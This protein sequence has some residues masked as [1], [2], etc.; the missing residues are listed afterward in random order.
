MA[1]TPEQ[2]AQLR[3]EVGE[4]ISAMSARMTTHEGAT[5]ESMAKIDEA[6]AN[7]TALWHT[8][9]AEITG[10]KEAINKLNAKIIENESKGSHKKKSIIDPKTM[11]PKVWNNDGSKTFAE[12]RDDVET[13]QDWQVPG[14]RDVL[15]KVSQWKVPITAEEFTKVLDEVQFGPGTEVQFGDGIDLYTFLKL[16]TEGDP[17]RQVNTISQGQGWEAWRHLHTTYEVRTALNKYQMRADV[18]GMVKHQGKKPA[19]MKDLLP[20]LEEKAK[21]YAELHDEIIPD[22]EIKGYLMNMLD[23]DSKKHMMMYNELPYAEYK[24]NLLTYVNTM[25]NKMEIGALGEQGT[26]QDMKQTR[27]MQS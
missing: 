1:A 22:I 24:A 18:S 15:R 14:M 17:K 19:D 3:T 21:R 6:Q 16:K 23:D 20:R 25:S 9:S 8:A 26:R 13:I 12:W 27:D 2:L 10:L 5:L 4:S 11:S 7:H